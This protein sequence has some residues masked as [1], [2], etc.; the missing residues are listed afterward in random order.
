MN[1]SVPREI[2]ER[3]TDARSQ[4]SNYESTWAMCDAFYQGRQNVV[5]SVDGT[6]RII[7][8]ASRRRTNAGSIEYKQVRNVILP[9]VATLVAKYNARIPGWSVD[10]ETGDPI[11]IANARSSEHA[12]RSI[13]DSQWL[14]RKFAEALTLMVNMGEGFIYPYWD[15][16]GGKM[17][18]EGVYEGE[19]GIRVLAPSSMLWERGLRYDEST[20]H[21][22]EVAFP[23]SYIEEHYGVKNPAP[24]AVNNGSLIDNVKANGQT[25]ANMVRVT[26]YL[27]RPC[28]G[29]PGQRLIIVGN[30]V[31]DE[32]PYPYADGFDEVSGQPWIVR[33][34]Y[35]V[36]PSADHDMG[37]TE[38]ALDTQRSINKT[39]NQQERNKDLRINPPTRS[40]KG[41]FTGTG[42]WIAGHNYEFTDPDGPPETIDFP[43]AT[44]AAQ[45]SL[46]RADSDMQ[47]ISGLTEVSQ[48]I[49]P[50]GVDNNAQVQSLAAQDESTRAAIL[51]QL[52]QSHGGLG[53][54]LLLLMRKNYSEKRLMRFTGKAGQ[55]GT[56]YF[57]S[58]MVPRRLNVRVSPG[59]LEFRTRADMEK[60]VLHY[61][62]LGWIDPRVAMAA[63]DAGT[64]ENILDD[65][66][67]DIQWQ[68]RENKRMAALKDT[69]ELEAALQID[70]AIRAKYQ[71][72]KLAA[73]QMQALEP[74]APVPD[75]PPP[76]GP[77]SH[78]R[79]F[80]NHKIHIETLNRYR[81]TEEFD[82]LSETVKEVFQ[83]HYEEHEDYMAREA[84]RQYEAQQA[85]A[86]EQGAA[87]AARPTRERGQP[88]APAPQL[89][90]Q[91]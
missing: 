31:V 68:Q 85:Q 19:I 70:A 1:K 25:S 66:E 59:S 11:D 54:R 15:A 58:E 21:A 89:T 46:D 56:M 61:A 80:D 45:F 34:S 5:P 81:K 86:M 33:Y 6:R 27:E 82:L 35:Y 36:N 75:P 57:K 41:S 37:F 9:T 79:E 69:P 32:G 24:D 74:Q 90:G 3:L 87:N 62:G 14:A 47:R 88:S 44:S 73:E 16:K 67:L 22:V 39:V 53:T 64:A 4:R 50:S 29:K 78:A 65:F 28:H 17:I 30:K 8:L 83:R 60:M 38:H 71:E 72:A 18:E 55:E 7:E 40:L 77:W 52:A 10:P 49:N 23:K 42:D 48:G 91:A 13:Y 43:D 76:S 12:L 84:A 26:E 20:W 51:K 2:E 63:I